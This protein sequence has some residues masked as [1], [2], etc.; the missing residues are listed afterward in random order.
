MTTNPA[1]TLSLTETPSKDHTKNL[2]SNPNLSPDSKKVAASKTKKSQDP[3]ESPQGRSLG[4]FIIDMANEHFERL[5]NGQ[6]LVQRAA[7]DASPPIPLSEWEARQRKRKRQTTIT[8]SF[9]ASSDLESAETAI[10]GD[11]DVEEEFNDVYTLGAQSDGDDTSDNERHSKRRTM[12]KRAVKSPAKAFDGPADANDGD[13]EGACGDD[14]DDG[15]WDSAKESRMVRSKANS[16][17]GWRE[18]VKRGRK[19]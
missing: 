19:Y 4:K 15:D 12:L 2:K 16:K 3:T 5:A 17:C 18:R 14:S 9:K 11:E 8:E 6:M 10:E 13:D 1:P 7:R